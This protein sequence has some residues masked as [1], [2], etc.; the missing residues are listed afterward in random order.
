MQT[1]MAKAV[2]KSDLR[3]KMDRIAKKFGIQQQMDWY[4]LT[5]QVKQISKTD[6][7]RKLILSDSLSRLLPIAY[8]EFEWNSLCFR[9]TFSNWRS[10]QNQRKMID[11]IGEQLGIE[12]QQ[13]WYNVSFAEVVSN[14]GAHTLLRKVHR[15][16][17]YSLLKTVYPE[18]EW[19]PFQFTI[20]PNNILVQP[21]RQKQQMDQIGHELGIEKQEDWYAVCVKD[22]KAHGGDTLITNYY[23]GSLY[24]ALQA[25][26]PEYNW[27]PLSFAFPPRKYLQ[28]ISPQHTLSHIRDVLDNDDHHWTTFAR[29]GD[30]FIQTHLVT[31]CWIL[32]P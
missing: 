29:Y 12:T 11:W 31:E 23:N 16:S 7:V 21:D 13:D 20:T 14:L 10:Q 26:Y 24:S 9:R 22:V 27:N 32:Q 1:K 15:G 18:F 2:M 25:I 8:P 17:T 5:H 30:E 4:S 6:P 19:N 28:I 3:R